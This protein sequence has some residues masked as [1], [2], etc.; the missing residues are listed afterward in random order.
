MDDV[1][2]LGQSGNRCNL[3]G[4]LTIRRYFLFA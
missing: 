2:N 4:L 3:D 1:V